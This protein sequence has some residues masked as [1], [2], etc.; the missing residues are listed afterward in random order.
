MESVPWDDDL[1]SGLID[2]HVRAVSPEQEAERFSLGLRGAMRKI[3]R[4]VGDGYFNAV[5]VDL[6]RDSDLT[7][8]PA[9]AVPIIFISA[10]L[11]MKSHTLRMPFHPPELRSSAGGLCWGRWSLS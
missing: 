1:N 11:C 5:L 8:D 10:T 2:L 4:E 6:I 9:I 3:E 7:Q